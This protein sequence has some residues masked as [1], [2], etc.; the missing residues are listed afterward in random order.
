MGASAFAAAAGLVPASA[1]AA[2]VF[3]GPTYVENFDSLSTTSSTTAFPTP[4]GTQSSVPGL[5]TW[6]GAQA[7]GTS[8]A[9]NM[10]FTADAGA[11]SSGAIYSY[12]AASSSERALGA[13]ASGS[14]IA[15]FGV[16]IQ[17]NTGAPISSFTLS[18]TAEQ[19]R[20]STSTTNVLAFAVGTSA[21]A[22]TSGYLTDADLTP[23][24][25]LDAPG[26]PFVV[27]NA[28]TDGNAPEF[29]TAVAG[30]VTLTSPVAPGEFIFLRWTD[31]NDVGNDAGIGIDNLIV[32]V[33]EP[34]GLLLFGACLAMPLMRRRRSR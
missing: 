29:Q 11:G 5:T 27:T 10:A 33:P 21:V 16:A 30:L 26:K 9:G 3:S 13:L 6:D 4:V 18:Y 23:V 17:N 19:W 2:V 24:T 32:A 31:A 8:T 7:G 25:A 1:D 34:S 22:T 28:A 20:S 15:T 12:G 14:R